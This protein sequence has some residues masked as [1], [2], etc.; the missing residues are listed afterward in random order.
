MQNYIKCPRNSGFCSSPL[1]NIVFHGDSVFIRT[2][3]EIRESRVIIE[4]TRFNQRPTG[5][6]RRDCGCRC[7]ELKRVCLITITR[8]TIIP[9][10]LAINYARQCRRSLTGA[11]TRR[12]TCLRAKIP[13]HVSIQFTNSEIGIE[14][15]LRTR[16]A[17][18]VNVLAFTCNENLSGAR[19][20]IIIESN[21]NPLTL[22]R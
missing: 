5:S 2:L 10:R 17:R 19:R 6:R 18:I 21:L 12:Y 1:G 7:L 11:K 3:L 13:S 20:N 9:A 8:P 4:E 15:A 16:D 22:L 14:Q